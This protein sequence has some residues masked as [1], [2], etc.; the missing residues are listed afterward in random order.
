MRVIWTVD[1]LGFIKYRKKKQK[2]EEY[3]RFMNVLAQGSKT[4]VETL[5]NKF[6]L[7]YTRIKD[8]DKPQQR[9]IN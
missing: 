2:H 3:R 9:D 4:F 1:Y 7:F 6:C 5:I 8:K